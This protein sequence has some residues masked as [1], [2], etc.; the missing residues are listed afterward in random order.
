MVRFRPAAYGST[1]L[2]GLR[3][4]SPAF[5]G[6]YEGANRH[7]NEEVKGFILSQVGLDEP[8][9]EPDLLHIDLDLRQVKVALRYKGSAL[10]DKEL[11]LRLVDP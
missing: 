7:R 8:L 9:S 4:S 3:A 2:L 10:R 6:R 11:M 1:A 5:S